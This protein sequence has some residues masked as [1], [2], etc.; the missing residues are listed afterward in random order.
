[1][2]KA[3]IFDFFGVICSEVIPVWS[4]QYLSDEQSKAIHD[5]DVRAADRGEISQTELVETYSQLLNKPQEDIRREWQSFARIN[6][7]VVERIRELKSTYKVALCSNAFSEFLIPLLEKENLTGLFDVIVISDQVKAVKPEPLI[8]QETLKRLGVMAEDAFLVDDNASNIEGA[9]R[10][11]IDG[12]V[13]TSINQ[14]ED[15]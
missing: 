9:K 1:M 10:L 2:K 12:I 5:A 6:T 3:L 14:L 7:D 15:L 11:G 4:K 13:F 8:F